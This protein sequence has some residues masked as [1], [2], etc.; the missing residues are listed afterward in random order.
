MR[1]QAP[2]L[3]AVL[4]VLSRHHEE[5]PH[6]GV[7][8]ESLYR[9]PISSASQIVLEKRVPKADEEHRLDQ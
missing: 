6:L 9:V 1:Y 5:Q 3:K 2:H 4:R 7:A 8:R